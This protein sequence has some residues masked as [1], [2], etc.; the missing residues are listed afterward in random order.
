[1]PSWFEAEVS[2]A[3]SMQSSRQ[4]TPRD[5]TRETSYCLFYECVHVRNSELQEDGSRLACLCYE[6]AL[7]VLP[8]IGHHY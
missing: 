6:L 5:C 7:R 8:S 4:G 3:C 2:K 1:M